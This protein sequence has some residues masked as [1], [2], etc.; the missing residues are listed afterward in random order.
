MNTK[1]ILNIYSKSVVG[2]GKRMCFLEDVS[3][4]NKTFKDNFSGLYAIT[5]NKRQ[6]M[7]EFTIHWQC[8]E[9]LCYY[10][11]QNLTG[12]TSGCIVGYAGTYHAL[13]RI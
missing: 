13:T 11:H 5:L 4:V 3:A 10:P 6:T 1:E 2:F 9:G 12:C 7:S 8:K